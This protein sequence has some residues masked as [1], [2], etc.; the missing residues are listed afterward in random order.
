MVMALHDT[1]PVR[2]VA[3]SKYMAGDDRVRA[4]ELHRFRYQD[5]EYYF[6]T[7]TLAVCFVTQLTEQA[8]EVA[9]DYISLNKLRQKLKETGA[10]QTEIDDVLQDLITQGFLKHE[11]ASIAPLPTDSGPS[12]TFM[13]NVSQRCNLTCP[14]CYVNEGLFDYPQKPIKRMPEK[15]FDGLVFK[16]LQQFTGFEIVT[17]HYYGGEPLLNFEAI[18]TITQQAVKAAEKQEIN[19]GFYITTNGTLINDQIADFFERYR[20][21]VYFS[22]DGDSE[23]HD[24]YRRYSNGRGSFDDVMANYE[25]I[26]KRPNIH[27][28]GSSVIRPGYSLSDALDFLQAHGADTCKAERVRLSEN[29]PIS[30]PSD[31]HDGYLADTREL[32]NHYIEAIDEGRKPMDFR[33]TAKIL[34]L[35]V[36][37]RR[38]FFCSAGERMFG[39][40]SNGEFYPCAL[41]VGRE[42]ALLGTVENGL[43]LEKVDRFRKKYAAE[44]QTNC[45]VCW[46]RNLCGGGC[47]AMI[48]RFG[49]EDCEAL[50]AES[51]AAIVVYAHFAQTDPLRLLALIS[52]ET[53]EWINRDPRES[54]CDAGPRVKQ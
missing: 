46:A 34:Q 4:R 25:R 36:K 21:N 22:I 7:G 2:V 37:K 3:D 16:L 48:D 43:C 17:F 20:F 8:V 1:L 33:L 24:M 6:S 11:N 29:N 44:S 40:A 28:I 38:N 19:V 12:V 45:R 13:V 54:R 30:L 5:R 18:K 31:L 32:V 10:K 50:R 14:Y 53:V 42:D 51:E 15:I 41:H 27:I 49:T 23:S 52:P 35:L 9:K 47:S 39:I 26:R